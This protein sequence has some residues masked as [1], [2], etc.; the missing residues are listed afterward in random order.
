MAKGGAPAKVVRKRHIP[1]RATPIATPEAAKEH[2][3]KKGIAAPTD[4]VPRSFVL[5]KGHLSRA[6][7]QL[8][9]DIR[10]VMEPHTAARLR[11]RRANKTRD[12][13]AMAGPLGVTHMLL[14][15]QSALGTVGLRIS[16]LPQGPTLHF[17]VQAYTLAHEIA[18]ANASANASGRRKAGGRAPCAA[19]YA[20]APLVV[21]NNF[22]VER[23]EGRLAA[24]MVQNMFPAVAAA[25]LRLA[26]VRRVVLFSY[27]QRPASDEAAE[28]DMDADAC[29][30]GV[31]HVRQYVVGVR[32]VGVS[33]TVRRIVRS[34]VPDLGR[35]PDAAAY[36][37]AAEALTSDSEHEAD[38]V[39][40]YPARSTPSTGSSTAQQKAVSLVECGPRMTLR[41]MKITEGL[42]TGRILY[43][44]KGT[45]D[46]SSSS[47]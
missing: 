43:H 6:A 27:E 12:F 40:P 46:A 14:V 39:V 4:A 15:S 44:H 3:E 8:V 5:H 29:G 33:R 35:F 13:V 45:R 22:P 16:R 36:V 28:D 20:A 34:Q 11:Q 25:S 30:D 32:H 24:S 31:F 2:A 37:L 41:L 26:D 1:S 23:S 47:Q 42:N 21:L 19:D 7:S 9:H 17:A 38:S 10:R 18:A